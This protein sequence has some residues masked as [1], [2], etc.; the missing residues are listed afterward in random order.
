M[1]VKEIRKL[2]RNELIDMKKECEMMIMMSSPKLN[3]P[4]IKPEQRKGVR[5]T[6]AQINTLLNEMEIKK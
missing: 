6:I 4:K 5:R 1:K 2:S 3:N